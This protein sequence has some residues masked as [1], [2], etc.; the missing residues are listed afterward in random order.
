MVTVPAFPDT[1][2]VTSPVRSEFTELKVTSSE[3]PIDC[4]MDTCPLDIATPV[5]AVTV[6]SLPA[7]PTKVTPDGQLSLALG[8]KIL[9]VEVLIKKS[10]FTPSFVSSGSDVP[11]RIVLPAAPAAPVSPISPLG[12]L[13]PTPAAPVS[14]LSPLG[15]VA[16]AAPTS[17]VA[18]TKETPADQLPLAL[19]PNILLVVVLI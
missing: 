16:P 13:T 5:P 17:P 7:A 10:P 12:P 2:P 1:S 4:P 9:F 15:P 8:P 19:G 18:P 3:V 14:P 11:F 6:A